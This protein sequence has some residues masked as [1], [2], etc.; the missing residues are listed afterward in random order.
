MNKLDLISHSALMIAAMYGYTEAMRL[1]IEAGADVNAKN[2]EGS[3]P[4]IMAIRKQNLKRVKRYVKDYVTNSESKFDCVQL[5]LEAGA[6]ANQCFSSTK[7]I[8]LS[9]AIFNRDANSTKLLLEYGSTIRSEY[10]RGIFRSVSQCKELTMDMDCLRLFYAA[11]A[12]E[13]EAM[14]TLDEHVVDE[15][16][17]RLRHLVRTFIRKRLLKRYPDSNLFI[18]IETLPLPSFLKSYLVYYMSLNISQV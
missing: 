14:R 3:S 9:F 4:L 12:G 11:V 17:L 1:L 5:L 8:P 10:F 15:E 16:P 7:V 6:D 18:V 13:H 2:W